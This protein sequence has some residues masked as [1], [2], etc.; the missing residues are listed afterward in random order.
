MATATYLHTAVVVPQSGLTS[1][2]S[3]TGAKAV[4]NRLYGW[5][6]GHARGLVSGLLYLFVR[7]RLRVRGLKEKPE[8]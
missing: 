6:L 8:L 2:D 1:A 4:E 5:K 3:T 7:G